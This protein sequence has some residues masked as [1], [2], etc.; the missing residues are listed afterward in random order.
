MPKNDFVKSLVHAICE[1][2]KD[3]QS[4]WAEDCALTTLSTMLGDVVIN[5]QEGAVHLNLFI[6]GLGASGIGKSKPVNAFVIPIIQQAQKKI[7]A[8]LKKV[9]KGDDQEQSA[10][11]Q[12]FE[13]LAFLLPER[14][15]I[16]GLIDFLSQHPGY[17]GLM[18]RD[19]LT[20]LIKATRKKDYQADD[21]EFLSE[22][23]DCKRQ[24]RY[25]ISHKHQVI[26]PPYIC[27]L[28]ATTTEALNVLDDGFF[29]QGSRQPLPLHLS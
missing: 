7:E 24:E 15:T 14:N 9:P 20:G 19:E 23:W 26:V 13:K 11:K 6:M 1:A 3:V 18:W 28:T 2:Q 27:F 8:E 4:S 29:R 12:E 25:T 5:E 21:L 22:L 16:E 10:E 17:Q